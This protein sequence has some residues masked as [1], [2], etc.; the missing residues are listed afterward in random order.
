MNFFLCE[1]VI[2]YQQAMIITKLMTF[3]VM[4]TATMKGSEPL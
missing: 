3:S 4:Y 1:N 2:N